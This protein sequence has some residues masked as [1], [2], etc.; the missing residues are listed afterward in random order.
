MAVVELLET[1]EIQRHGRQ[2]CPTMDPGEQRL[3]LMIECPSVQQTGEAVGGR[4]QLGAQLFL[5]G[6]LEPIGQGQGQQHPIQHQ[7]QIQCLVTPIAVRQHPH[8]GEGRHQGAQQAAGRP[9]QKEASRFVTA[10]PGKTAHQTAITAG[11]AG[12]QDGQMH[13]SGIAQQ[14]AQQGHPQHPPDEQPG[15]T[16]QLAVALR[17]PQ[18]G[19][20]KHQPGDQKSEDAAGLYPVLPIR[21]LGKQ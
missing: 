7:P 13:M 5:P 3:S 21:M 9:Q 20:G 11:Q 8:D 14:R 19:T 6:L 16:C 1:V 4:L 12:K 15:E 10:P 2:G 17:Q 18:K